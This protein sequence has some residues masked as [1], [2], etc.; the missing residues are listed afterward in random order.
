[1]SAPRPVEAQGINRYLALLFLLLSTATLFDGFDAGLLSFAA[2]EV[3]ESLDISRSEW[4][5]VTS[6]T[7]LGV[8]ASFLFLLSADRWGRRKLLMVTIAGYTLFTFLTGLAPNVWSFAAA[9]FVARVF[10]IGCGAAN[11]SGV[12]SCTS[13]PRCSCPLEI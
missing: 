6:L 7:R 1:M 9:Q 12:S 11:T 3:R 5:Y 13:P 10:L 2:P 8:M 4:G